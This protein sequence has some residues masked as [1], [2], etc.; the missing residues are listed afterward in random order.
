[1]KDNSFSEILLSTDWLIEQYKKHKF[2]CA[3]V[4]KVFEKVI[5]H[6]LSEVSLSVQKEL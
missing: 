3:C 4:F 2:C 6:V 1:M 5:S